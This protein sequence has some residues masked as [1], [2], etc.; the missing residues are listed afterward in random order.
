MAIDPNRRLSVTSFHADHHITSLTIS[1][2]LSSWPQCHPKDS[3]SKSNRV[4]GP[5]ADHP[6]IADHPKT[7]NIY[8][9][10]NHVLYHNQ[11]K[12]SIIVQSDVGNVFVFFP[13]LIWTLR[14]HLMSLLQNKLYSSG[15]RSEG[16]VV[17]V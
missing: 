12:Q 2:L 15:G 16:S 13:Y 10:S 7:C 1:R 14:P 6:P 17:I 4:K 9:Q 8:V 3:P 5:V 11:L